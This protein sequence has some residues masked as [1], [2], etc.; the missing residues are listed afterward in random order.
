MS[1]NIALNC[2]C[3]D[4]V[5]SVTP[6]NAGGVMAYNLNTGEMGASELG[7]AVS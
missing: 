3:C 2:P 7:Q 1:W 6:H 5:M 4:R